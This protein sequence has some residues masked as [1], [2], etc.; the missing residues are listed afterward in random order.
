MD[1]VGALPSRF[2]DGMTPGQP[3]WS[4]G[5]GLPSLLISDTV[6]TLLFHRPIRFWLRWLPL[7]FGWSLAFLTHLVLPGRWRKTRG[8]GVLG[9][10]N[11]FQPWP[12]L[13]SAGVNPPPLVCRE[14]HASLTHVKLC[15]RS[16]AEHTECESQPLLGQN[17][18]QSAQQ[19]PSVNKA[20]F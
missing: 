20:G 12:E 15:A 1:L 13:V 16:Q 17:C 10:R 14:A 2:T 8:P 5:T 3:Q 18:E 11:H 19:A 6:Y 4:W 9:V 7:P